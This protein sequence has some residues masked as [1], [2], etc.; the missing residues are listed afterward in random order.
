MA[1]VKVT[2]GTGKVVILKQLEVGD[3]E[4]ALEA[5]GSNVSTNP[6]LAGAKAQ[7]ELLKM[8]LVAVDG[9]ELTG[10]EKEFLKNLFSVGEYSQLIE[11]IGKMG[12]AEG[13]PQVELLTE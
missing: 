10:N 11:V 6:I 4:K 12:E 7:V 3:Q 5:L 1:K 9:K 8:L 13:K 2:L